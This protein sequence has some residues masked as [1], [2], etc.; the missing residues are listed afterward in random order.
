MKIAVARAVAIVGVEIDAVI[1]DLPDFDEGIAHRLAGSAKNA[2]GQMGYLAQ[3]RRER[4]VD[5]DQIVVGVQRQLV[6]IER[7]LGQSRRDGQLFGPGSPGK[8]SG[9]RQGKPFE[10]TPPIDGEIAEMHGLAPRMFRCC[11]RQN[12]AARLPT[13]MIL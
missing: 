1:I 7:A 11:P 9:G 4:I 13:M 6:G 5:N 2:A 3:C 8:R 12:V 10:Q